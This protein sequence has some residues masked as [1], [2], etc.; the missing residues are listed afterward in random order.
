MSFKKSDHMAFEV[1]S[2]SEFEELVA[3]VELL[4]KEVS[5]LKEMG[6]PELVTV[7]QAAEMLKRDPKT[8]LRMCKAKV[9]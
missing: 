2:K 4:K 6:F 5:V 3:V 7:K 8:I 1:V 9:Q